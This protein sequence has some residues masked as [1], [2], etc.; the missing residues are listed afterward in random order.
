MRRITDFHS[1]EKNN[2][3][4]CFSRGGGCERSERSP[5]VTKTK[6]ST[7]EVKRT[8]CFC[9]EN[10]RQRIFTGRMWTKW[11]QSRRYKNKSERN[12]SFWGQSPKNLFQKNPRLRIFFPRYS[13]RSEESVSTF[14]YSELSWI[15]FQNLFQKSKKKRFKK[16]FFLKERYYTIRSIV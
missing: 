15:L 11:T 10:P 4:N 14:C 1:A 12:S 5:E 6:V 9:E 16:F 13:E 8:A 7:N 2:P 3:V